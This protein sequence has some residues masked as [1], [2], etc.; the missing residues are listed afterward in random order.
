MSLSP[1]HPVLPPVFPFY[2]YISGFIFSP[3][4]YVLFAVLYLLLTCCWLCLG[5]CLR[6]NTW[7]W[8][9]SCCIDSRMPE[10]CCSVTPAWSWVHC[11]PPP[12][13]LGFWHLVRGPSL[14]ETQA[15]CVFSIGIIGLPTD[16]LGFLA[17]SFPLELWVIPPLLGEYWSHLFLPWSWKLLVF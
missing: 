7:F 3:K 14:A 13:A 11:C 15:L 4:M 5:N 8:E 10:S 17:L 16:A 2:C 9:V 6:Q 12:G 1:L